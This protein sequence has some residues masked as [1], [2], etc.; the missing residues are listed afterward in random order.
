MSQAR[1]RNES[2]SIHERRADLIRLC[3]TK[4]SQGIVKL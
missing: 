1:T 4:R 2:L 3:G